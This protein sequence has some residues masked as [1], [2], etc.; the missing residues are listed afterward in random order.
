[1]KKSTFLK[2]ALVGASFLVA[3]LCPPA[4]IAVG[5]YIGVAAATT[6]AGA[7]GLGI[8]GA[9][10]G[11]IAGGIVGGIISLPGKLYLAAKLAKKGTEIV[12]EDSLFP[13][14]PTSTSS[15]SKLGVKS[16]FTAANTNVVAKVAP[17]ASANKNLLRLVAGR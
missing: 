8:A 14:L 4:A 9:V 7:I 16:D 13:S 2:G 11:S 17:A 15:L 1:M 5:A 10:A 3:A 6:T 12:K